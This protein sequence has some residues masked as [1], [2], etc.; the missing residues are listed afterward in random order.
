MFNLFSLVLIIFALVL[1]LIFSILNKK[2]KRIRD[3]DITQGCDS[4]ELNLYEQKCETKSD[5][6]FST[7]EKADQFDESEILHVLNSQPIYDDLKLENG[8]DQVIPQNEIPDLPPRK[9]EHTE[10]SSVKSTDDYMPMDATNL[11]KDI[12]NYEEINS[13]NI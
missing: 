12:N 6:E 13:A 8:I 11:T 4:V 10:T 2:N 5:T 9:L 1:V 3:S 7:F